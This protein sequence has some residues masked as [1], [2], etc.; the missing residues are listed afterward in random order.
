MKT[1]SGFL[2]RN[3]II[4]LLYTSDYFAPYVCAN[5]D[6]I[7]EEYKDPD[8]KWIGESP[9]PMVLFYNKDLIEKDGMTIPAVSY[10]HL[11]V[12]KRQVL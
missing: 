12:Y 7:A 5:D 2:Q 9:L 6:V 8:D 4:C 10:T 3:I 11:D 1:T